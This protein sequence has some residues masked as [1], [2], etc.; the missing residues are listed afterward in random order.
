MTSK[1]IIMENETG[2]HARP[3]NELVSFIKEIECS[4]EIENEAGKK[5]K[6]SSLLKVL[7]LGVK[8]GSKITIYCDGK[9]EEATL[10]KIV[11]FI[12]NLKD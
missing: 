10:E 8:K 7:S 4:V 5:V 11:D 3:A 1:S 2:L 6:G 9:D 12:K